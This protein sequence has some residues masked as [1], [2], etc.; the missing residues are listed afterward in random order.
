MIP[1]YKGRV[2]VIMGVYN[3]SSTVIDAIKSIE[4]QT[5]TDWHFYICDDGSTDGTYDVI[6]QYVKDDQRFTLLKN[7]KN[8]GL[9]YSLNR[10]LKFS[11]DEFIARMDGDDLCDPHR[12]EKQVKVLNEHP[13]YHICGTAM[14]FF[15]ENGYWGSNTVPEFPSAEQVVSGT[16]ICH[17]T[18]MART[19]AYRRVNGYSQ[20]PSTLRVEDVDLWIRMYEKGFRCINIQEPLYHMRNDQNA[21]NRRKYIYRINSTKTRLRG[22]KSLHLGPKSYIKAFKP[23]LYGLVPSQLRRLI[24]HKSSYKNK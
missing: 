5:Y 8:C 9:N 16:P 19:S 11:R 20:D 21:L 10:C 6:S 4:N 14:Q 13:E 23:M 1:F 17:A 15:D 2:A 18:I 12:F 3:C 7:D 24:R 22:C